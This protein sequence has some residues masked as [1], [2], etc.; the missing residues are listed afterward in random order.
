MINARAFLTNIP[1]P[2]KQKC[3]NVFISV[4]KQVMGTG[5]FILLLQNNIKVQ[6]FDLEGDY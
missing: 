4:I 1:L 2:I 3:L 5:V 6:A